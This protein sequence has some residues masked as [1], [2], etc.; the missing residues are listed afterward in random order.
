MSFEDP[1]IAVA[2]IALIGAGFSLL[3]TV[4]MAL[5]NVKNTQMNASDKI[6]IG[7]SALLDELREERDQDKAELKLIKHELEEIKLWRIEVTGFIVPFIEGSKANERQL[8]EA[9][10]IPVYKLPP[11]PAWLNGD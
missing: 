3:G 1:T 8:I 11:F 10:M 6:A 9:D 4:I 7:A 2:V 5:A